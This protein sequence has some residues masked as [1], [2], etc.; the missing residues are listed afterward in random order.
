MF[1]F[2]SVSIKVASLNAQWGQSL[3]LFSPLLL[4]WSILH[5]SFFTLLRDQRRSRG[6]DARRRRR[7]VAIGPRGLVF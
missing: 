7:H 6:K 1:L 2:F 5:A 3:L 4:F